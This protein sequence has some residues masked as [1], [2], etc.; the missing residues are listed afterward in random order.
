MS[1]SESKGFSR[2]FVGVL[3]AA[4]IGLG[5]LPGCGSSSNAGASADG[6]VSGTFTGTAVGM[7]GE[8]NPVEVT[9]TLE[10]SKIVDA[11]AT[12]AGETEGIGSKAIDTMPGE[13]KSSG[14]IAVDTVSGATITSN[15]ILEAAAAALTSAGLNPDDYKTAAASTAAAAEDVTKDVDIVIVGAG[16]AGMTA[17]IKAADEGASVVILE[18]QAMAGGNSVRSTGGMNAAKTVYQDENEFDESAGVE[19]T[20]KSARENYADN[21]DIQALADTVEKQWADYQANPEGYFDSVELFELDTMIGGKGINDI[22]LVKTLAENSSDAIDWLESIGATLHNVGQFG[23]ASV[24]RIHRPVNDQGKTTAVGAYVIPILEKNVEDRGDEI[25]Y[26][27]TADQILT[28]SDGNV[29]GVHATTADGGNV[30]V[31]AKAVILATGGF[32]A[33]NDMV[34]AQNHPELK[35][36]ITTNA[37]GAQGQGITMAE[38]IGAGTVDMDQI[39][40]HPTVHVD[41]DGNAHLIT[42][43]LRGDGAILV[44]KE[45]NRFFNEVG[46]RDAVSN[47]ENE[48][49]DGQAWLVIDQAMVD[50]SAVIAG[51]ISAGYTVT[52][53]TY[54]ELADAMGVP[55]DT[56]A[57]TMEKWNECVANQSDPDFNRVSFA[58]PLDTAPYY[59]IL[60]QPGI[61]HTMG[62]LTIDTSCEVLDGVHGNV[63]P[64]LFAAGEVT[65]GV[66]GANRLGGNAVADFVVFGG[67][68]GESAA[69][70]VKK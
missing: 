10:D 14:S 32:G 47:A 17:A 35:G 7:G 42:E 16:G 61:H 56:F 40:L 3:F 70:Y 12:G 41:D 23:G 8:S 55:A 1:L 58:N 36:Y 54:E 64:G 26:N 27:T 11:T 39:Q 2:T 33:N 69:A 57:A 67:I 18:S 19:A 38:A 34:V 37:A 13:I 46:T 45:G 43:G 59:A 48:Q 9:L 31:N 68:A 21:A 51:Y 28:D 30:T 65:G 66:H 29:A 24:K 60:V 4:A 62:G 50:A 53:S 15:A 49:T 22:E 52:G 63:I 25:L 44:N 6:G 20:L 5:T